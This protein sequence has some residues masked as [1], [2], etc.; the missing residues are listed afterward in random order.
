M[1]LRSSPAGHQH[2]KSHSGLQAYS[3][4][5]AA[6]L[7][8]PMDRSSSSGGLA[9]SPS[10]THPAHL[11]PSA[12][13]GNKLRASIDASRGMYAA[14]S[15][16]LSQ[17]N[18]NVGGP[19]GSPSL[20][21]PRSGSKRPSSE[22]LA[23]S[24][25]PGLGVGGP[26]AESE[27]LSR[28]LLCVQVE[29]DVTLFGNGADDAIDKW[30]EDLHHYE[31]TL[32]EMA[33]ASLDQSFKEELGAIEQ[34][35]R[36]LSEAERTA[37]LYSLLQSS[38][39]VQIRFFITVLQQMARSDPMTALLS[40]ANP[41][42]ATMEA[43]MEAKL[44]SFGLK[45]PASP[46]V[47]Q[48]ARQSLGSV[49]NADLSGFLSPNSAMQH[50]SSSSP[51]ARHAS[52]DDPQNAGLGTDAAALLA[53]QRARLNANASN[54][55]SAPGSLLS[56]YDLGG[57]KSPLWSQANTDQVAERSGRSPSPDGR[58]SNPSRSR[59][60]SMISDHGGGFNPAAS[61]ATTATGLG[62]PA[63]TTAGNLA[64]NLN[65]I[66]AGNPL[67]SSSL[68]T[69]ANLL[70]M[71]DAQLSPLLNNQNWAA[72][73]QTPLMSSFN[74]GDNPDMSSSRTTNWANQSV[75]ASNIVLDDV[76]KFRR[77]GRASDTAVEH[78]NGGAGLNANAN[79]NVQGIL[80]GMYAEQNRRNAAVQQQQPQQYS[81][82]QAFNS[83]PN[84]TLSNANQA[85]ALSAQQNWRNI[86]G[87]MNSISPHQSGSSQSSDLNNLANLQAA[88][89]GIASP[90]MQMASLI[91]AQQQIQQQMQLQQNLNM[92]N[93]AGI[94][95]MGMM[96]NQQMM[97][98]GESITLRQLSV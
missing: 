50:P 73:M 81:T 59:P 20:G 36:V 66:S 16:N 97:S 76:K 4:P 65:A 62:G 44:A 82:Q 19:G 95:P 46:V 52:L 1:S 30:F 41:Q 54:R 43:Q 49:P 68:D 63:S 51:S 72:M 12:T 37:A 88:M 70:N 71:A 23:G 34:W 9:V 55:I 31:T 33:A 96:P 47:R 15:A 61:S 77:Q 38:S 90:Q 10:P 83:A 5:V 98:P 67:R 11:S 18:G 6:L 42:Q 85:A 25:L 56:T 45:S 86:N 75:N 35:F 58:A 84:A 79:A 48:F 27:L 2:S 21:P 94:S 69:N 13:Q 32:E 26:N 14:P 7:G 78:F 22:L 64:N 39:Q 74:G 17:G 89:Q 3:T 8:N 29:S 57:L 92:L 80:N 28:L 91:A 93:M 24:A 87:V 40:P 53:Q 60:S